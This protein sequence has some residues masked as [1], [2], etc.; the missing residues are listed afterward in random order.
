M[1][2]SL[3]IDLFLDFQQVHLDF[4]LS[5]VG[6]AKCTES[7]EEVTGS[8]SEL[9]LIAHADDRLG[10]VRSEVRGEP[11]G[12]LGVLESNHLIPV[13]Q[14]QIVVACSQHIVTATVA[15]VV[16]TALR[17]AS[18]A[19]ARETLNL[20]VLDEVLDVEGPPE[21]LRQPLQVDIEV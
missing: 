12:Q 10:V 4:I 17:N 15:L 16:L 7:R 2:Q 5:A 18:T 13:L 21:Q 14:K 8:G 1:L 6:L 11:V 20:C 9:L 3:Y 19:S